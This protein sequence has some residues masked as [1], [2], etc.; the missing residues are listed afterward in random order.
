[1]EQFDMLVCDKMEIDSVGTEEGYNT[2]SDYNMELIEYYKS[3]TIF[4][5]L[6][7][8]IVLKIISFLDEDTVTVGRVCRYWNGL[9]FREIYDRGMAE[10]EVYQD[11]FKAIVEFTRAILINPSSPS[12][13]FKRGVAHYKECEEKEAVRNITKALSLSPSTV[14]YYLMKAMLHQIQLT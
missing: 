9:A 6:P 7:T 1:M 3:D 5:I 13:W 14:E 2:I 8:E 11:N 10:M 12:P 4:K